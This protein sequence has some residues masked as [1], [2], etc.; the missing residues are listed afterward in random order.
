MSLNIDAVLLR[1]EAGLARVE[2]KLDDH[3]R[4]Q[5]DEQARGQQWKL[6]LFGGL[7]GSGILSAV[8]TLLL[9]ARP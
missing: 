7:M 1:L 3:I 2:Q 9:R 8:I 4:V 5:N 6:A